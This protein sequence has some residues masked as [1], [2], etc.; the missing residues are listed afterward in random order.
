FRPLSSAQAGKDG[1]GRQP[2]A[3]AYPSRSRLAVPDRRSAGMTEPRKPAAF[4]I[5]PQP[6]ADL[7]PQDAKQ[8]RR[9]RALKAEVALVTPAEIDVFDDGDDVAATPPPATRRK[10]SKLGAFFMAALGILLS[11]AIGLWTDQL[12]RD[13]FARADWLGWLALG[14]ALVAAL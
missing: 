1:G 12:I 2:V 8:P 11:L 6:E 4:R 13:L 3:A 14:V 7:P 9:P 10:R 5:D